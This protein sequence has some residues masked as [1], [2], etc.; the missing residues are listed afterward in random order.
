[1][2]DTKKING[3]D[4]VWNIFENDWVTVE[5]WEYVNGIP[6]SKDPAVRSYA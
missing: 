5:Y 4:H 2:A 6:G 1:M 3:V